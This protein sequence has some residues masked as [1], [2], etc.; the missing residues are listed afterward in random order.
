MSVVLSSWSCTLYTWKFFFIKITVWYMVLTHKNLR[1]I[2]SL[3][4]SLSVSVSLCL[5]STQFSKLPSFLPSMKLYRQKCYELICINANVG[6]G[7]WPQSPSNQFFP[8]P[9]G[10]PLR[11]FY[12]DQTICFWAILLTDTQGQ[13]I[14][15]FDCITWFVR[16]I[17]GTEC[18]Y[19][20]LQP[21][22]ISFG[23]CILDLSAVPSRMYTKLFTS[24]SNSCT[25]QLQ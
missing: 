8:I 9:Q 14:K 25:K 2:C 17:N 7:L 24:L 1:K 15:W 5:G 23:S 3:S 6:V 19:M 10:R 12:H 20:Y 11:K 16:I 22:L 21:C 18:V 13:T 4:F